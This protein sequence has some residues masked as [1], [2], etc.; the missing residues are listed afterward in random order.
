MVM[1]HCRTVF[2]SNVHLGTHEC[3]AAYLLD[4]LPR[5][6]CGKLYLVGGTIDLEAL[7]RCSVWQAEHGVVVAELLA[8]ARPAWPAHRRR[9]HPASRVARGR[10]RPPLSGQLRRRVRPRADRSSLAAVAGARRCTAVC[11]GTTRAGC[12]PAAGTALPAAVDH[13][14]AARCEIHAMQEGP[15]RASVSGLSWR[16]RLKQRS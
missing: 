14:P 12:A 6:R 7:G 1:F 3:K 15:L 2:I 9:T 5:L 8:M 10:R 11:W 13:R 16:C 4:F